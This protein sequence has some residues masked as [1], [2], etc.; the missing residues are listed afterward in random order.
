LT[1]TKKRDSRKR[2]RKKW[3]TIARSSGEKGKQWNK[4]HQESCMQ[5]RKH[6]DLLGMQVP[7]IIACELHLH[8]DISVSHIVDDR[9]LSGALAEWTVWFYTL[10]TMKGIP[11]WAFDGLPLCSVN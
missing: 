6:N 1:N 9:T 4:K 8:Y 10:L 11:C 5:T 2:I 7:N 3:Y